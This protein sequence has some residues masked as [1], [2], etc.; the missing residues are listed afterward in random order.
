MLKS[1][2]DFDKLLKHPNNGMN[3]IT[4]ATKVIG[5]GNHGNQSHEGKNAG[6]QIRDKESQ[7]IVG[8][9]STLIGGKVT[10]ELMGT[11]ES[12]VSSYKHGMNGS[13]VPNG[14]LKSK[15]DE[16]LDRINDKVVDKVDQL[17]DIFAE[18]KMS[19]LK[20]HEIPSSA[21]KLI[22]MFDKIKR[23]NDENGSNYIRP[24]V[25]L[26]APKQINITEL[27]SKEVE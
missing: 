6:H 17:L 26:W 3:K 5:S 8:V 14:E 10:A 16:K 12:A 27:I 18:D 13:R 1:D 25:L 23:R 15:I 20:A 2:E 19:E 4:V 22:S 24:Q 7:A 21:E 9:L 11:S